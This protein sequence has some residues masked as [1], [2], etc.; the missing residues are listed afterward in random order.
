MNNK[1]ASIGD[2]TNIARG[3][4][5]G[6]SRPS[7]EEL[8]QMLTQKNE[9]IA[10]QNEV[11]A[12]AH[13]IT[14]N[15][16]ESYSHRIVDLELLF[17]NPDAV[18]QGQEMIL[19]VAYTRSVI[20]LG[21]DTMACYLAAK[22][23]A[24]GIVYDYETVKQ[25]ETPEGEKATFRNESS[26]RF[27]PNS[28]S[29]TDTKASEATLKQREGAKKRAD[30]R[31]EK[32]KQSLVVCSSCGQS[33][34]MHIGLVPVCG[35]CGHV[36]VLDGSNPDALVKAEDVRIVVADNSVCSTP[37][38]QVTGSDGLETVT[39]EYE[40]EPAHAPK[41]TIVPPRKKCAPTFGKP[42]PTQCPDCHE[43]AVFK[44]ELTGRKECITCNT[45]GKPGKKAV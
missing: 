8:E 17:S 6:D 43:Y 20:G 35:A 2:A 13:K 16:R 29:S 32:L 5:Q 38:E 30:T 33:S 26:I 45:F 31:L 23:D 12:C 11:I 21:H 44:D 28:F 24:G 39:I 25:G 7:Y 22:T 10:R 40:E 1:K 3:K 14:R 27:L 42:A 34:E 36:G 9:V 37:T 15:Q 41:L 18:L 19:N 4:T